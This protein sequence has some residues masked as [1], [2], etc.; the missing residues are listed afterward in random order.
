M[1]TKAFKL[2]TKIGVNSNLFKFLYAFTFTFLFLQTSFLLAGDIADNISRIR[3]NLSRLHKSN[4]STDLAEIEH[5]TEQLLAITKANI[6]RRNMLAAE[7]EYGIPEL[8]RSLEENRKMDRNTPGYY[9]LYGNTDSDETQ[10]VF[11]SLLRARESARNSLPARL[12]TD[13]NY[14]LI[15]IYEKE[16]HRIR[17]G[18]ALPL[19]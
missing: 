19:K 11:N 18:K 1:P 8:E 16:F 15:Q 3:S 9:R 2:K 17:S 4:T 12:L 5:Q 6:M 7:A 14:Q 10:V 13:S